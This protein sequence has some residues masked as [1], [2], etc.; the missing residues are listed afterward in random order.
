MEISYPNLTNFNN[1]YHLCAL[2]QTFAELLF[3]LCILAS[4]SPIDRETGR[5]KS[6][7]PP[8]NPA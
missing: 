8:R 2:W 4:G 5:E 6:G 1:T 7:I 3:L